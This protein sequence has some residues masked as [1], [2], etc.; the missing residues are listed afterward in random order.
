M[1]LGEIILIVGSVIAL[2]TM[3]FWSHFAAEAAQ[4]EKR[5]KQNDR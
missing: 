5:R 3:V 1:T 2:G 4:L